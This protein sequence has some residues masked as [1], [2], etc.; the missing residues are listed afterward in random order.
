MAIIEISDSTFSKYIGKA[1]VIL[2]IAISIAL[3]ILSIG[4][5]KSLSNSYLKLDTEQLINY[6]QGK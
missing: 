5:Y 2:S 3:L 1:I 4:I 6:K